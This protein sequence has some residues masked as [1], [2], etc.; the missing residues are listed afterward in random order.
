MTTAAKL[1]KHYPKLTADERYPLVLAAVTR[2]DDAETTRLMAAAPRL[3]CRVPDI[4]NRMRAFLD[5]AYRHAIRRLETAVA[6]HRFGLVARCRPEEADAAGWTAAARHAGYLLQVQAA[7]WA[8]FC[9]A[10][11]LDADA[12]A[13]LTAG[14]GWLELATEW[15]ALIAFTEAEARAY[16][17]GGACDETSGE[18]DDPTKPF[19]TAVVEAAELE[20]WFAERLA[21][22]G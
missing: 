21:Q 14:G 20:G 19:R 6:Y 2:D 9:A 22:G 7:G 13:A 15:S 11:H 4:H 10:R 8:L 12:A 1:D 17:S 16:M 5:V 3:D 18:V